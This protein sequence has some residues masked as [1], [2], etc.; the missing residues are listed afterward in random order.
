M[1]RGHQGGPP[2]RAPRFRRC[3]AGRGGLKHGLVEAGDGREPTR[4][5]EAEGMGIVDELTGEVVGIDL[6]PVLIKVLKDFL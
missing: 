4:D 1:R 5:G 6:A 2:G 3:S